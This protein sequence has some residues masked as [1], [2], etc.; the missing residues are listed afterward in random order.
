MKLRGAFIIVVT[1]VIAVFTFYPRDLVGIIGEEPDFNENAHVRVISRENVEDP[2][3]AREMISEDRAREI[4]EYLENFKYMKSN[5]NYSDLDHLSSFTIKITD[6]AEEIFFVTIRGEKYISINDKRD[7]Y[8]TYRVWRDD[9]DL[10][11]VGA[12]YMS[13]EDI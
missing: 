10:E 4:Y 5:K 9:F 1:L 2:G 12:F 11:H 13:L 7:N 3:I 6:G 8:F